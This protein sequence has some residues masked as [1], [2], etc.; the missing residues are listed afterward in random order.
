MAFSSLPPPI[1][2]GDGV[3]PDPIYSKDEDDPDK[4]GGW[5]EIVLCHLHLP[6][7]GVIFL[8]AKST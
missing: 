5:Y 1:E 7:I 4:K 8:L 2:D 6:I 3:D